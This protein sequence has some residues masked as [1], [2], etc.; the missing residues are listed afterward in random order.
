MHPL[1]RVILA[2]IGAVL[3]VTLAGKDVYFLAAVV[4]TLLGLA[5]GEI[6]SL[7]KSSRSLEEQLRALRESIIR[8]PATPSERTES[9]HRPPEAARLAPSAPTV[10]APIPSVRVAREI[11]WKPSETPTPPA[12]ENDNV[13]IRRLREYFTGGNTLVRSGV[14]VLFFGVAFLLR[15]LAEHSHLPIE[16]RLAGVACGALVLLALGW[17]VRSSRPGYALA[18]QGGAIGVLYLTVFSALRLYMLLSPAAAFALLAALAALCAIL[19]ILQDSMAV[20]LLAVTGGFLAPFLAST[21]AGDHV[22]LFSY[23]VVLNSAIAAIAWFRSWRLL[24]LA[25]FAFTFALSTMWGVLQYRPQDFASTEPFLVGT[26]PVRPPPSMAI[27]MGRSFS[28]HR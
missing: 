21:G 2:I 6:A 13:I 19:A 27:S 25:G 20:A 12:A 1:I 11:E 22:T 17:R 23:F 15:Y 8:R 18:L 10:S 26:A 7:R 5:I 9:T 16:L 3:G 28:A 4:G 24:N 14:V